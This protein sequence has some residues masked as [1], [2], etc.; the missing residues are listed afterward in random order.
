MF[1][2]VILKVVLTRQNGVQEMLH[3]C[4]LRHPFRMLRP[5]IYTFFNYFFEIHIYY[6][7]NSYYM[8]RFCCD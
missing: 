5:A 6:E 7:S 3:S 4:V 8:L 1:S 2:Q